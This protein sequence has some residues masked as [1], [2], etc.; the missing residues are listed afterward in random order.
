[1]LNSAYFLDQGDNVDRRTFGKHHF[2]FFISEDR[3]HECAA[4]LGR[5]GQEM[6]LSLN[7]TVV[8]FLDF[9]QR[10]STLNKTVQL[11]RLCIF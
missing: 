8:N 7:Y 11:H 6:T 5:T 4:P 1:M 9:Q 10:I 2:H 3:I